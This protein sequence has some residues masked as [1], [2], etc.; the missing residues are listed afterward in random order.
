[1][2]RRIG[3]TLVELLVVIAI[4]G[5]LIALLLPAVQAARE[6]AR[7]T[8]CNN[9]IKQLG[10]GMH[11]Y[12]DSYKQFAIGTPHQDPNSPPISNMW[13]AGIHRKGSELVKLL[14]YI[15]QSP[16]YE[17]LNFSEDVVAQLAQL[18]YAWGAGQTHKD[19]PTMRCP[20]DPFTENESHS[21]Y[22]KSMGFQP[23]PGRS[24]NDYAPPNVTHFHS[25][26]TGHGSRNARDGAVQRISGCFS[27]FD[28][29]AKIRD[30]TDGT[31][32]T[33]LMG[34]VRPECGDHMRTG[35]FSNPNALWTAT[36]APINYPTC[37]N[38][39]PGFEGTDGC[40]A[41]GNWQT[42]Q[43]FK[44]KH[45]GGAQFVFADGS[46]H[47][48]SETIDYYT[49]QRLGDRWDNQPVGQY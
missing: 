26:L 42:S 2:F 19:L 41:V 21:N 28:W 14:P 16:L 23:M 11:N 10:L 18:G 49:Y 47:F 22:A 20:S 40:N 33:I 45:P 37:P 36:T 27:R 34:E 6:A 30:I 43:G 3:F 1:M 25:G 17:Q 31:S 5:I 9:H 48:L 44:S 39:P 4:I 8:Q 13:S 32:N 38:E 29:A 7:R 24:C 35:S 12:H 15:E 46:G